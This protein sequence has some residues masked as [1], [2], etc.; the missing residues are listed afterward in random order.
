VAVSDTFGALN[1]LRPGG[2]IITLT[3]DLP[4]AHVILLWLPD[5]QNLLVEYAARA[6]IVSIPQ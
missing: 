6:W 3:S 1:I 5:D 2:S 4:G